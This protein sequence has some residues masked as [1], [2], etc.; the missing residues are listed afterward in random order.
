MTFLL[1]LFFGVD[2]GLH[3]ACF[4]GRN[5]YRKKRGLFIVEEVGLEL[6]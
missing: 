5:R 2:Q 4:A 3:F 6:V 1:V